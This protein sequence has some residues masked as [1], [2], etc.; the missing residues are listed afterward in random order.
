MS[1]LGKTFQTLV[2]KILLA[3]VSLLGSVLIVR[4]VGAEGQGVLATVYAFFM[5]ISTIFFLSLGSSMIYHI[6][7][8]GDSEKYFSASLIMYFALTGLTIL[9]TIVFIDVIQVYILK[10]LN[11]QYLY[12]GWALISANNLGKISSAICRATHNSNLFNSILVLQR[13][14]YF[15]PILIGYLLSF[16]IDT[17]SVIWVFL[18]STFISNL[19]AIVV[20]RK[21]FSFRKIEFNSMRQLLS[22]SGKGHIGVMIQVIN[23]KIDI[24]ILNALLTNPQVGYYSIAVLFA[25]LVWY[26]PDSVATFLYPK[27]S[28][29]NN[30]HKSLE[31]TMRINRIVLFV[32]IIIAFIIFYISPYL[33]PAIYPEDFKNSIYAIQLLIIGVAIYSINKILTKF[34]TGTGRPIVGSIISL[35]GLF[36]NIPL[37]VYLI[38]EY[39][40]NGAAIASTVAYSVMGLCA[41]FALKYLHPN[42][43]V[44]S[45]LLINKTDV[46]YLYSVLV[47]IFHRK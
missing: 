29:F 16:K 39:G 26:V 21:F 45:V 32:S 40:I 19:V 9:L 20:N 30:T 8:T 38:P 18:I 35:I 6:N 41:I 37:L 10:D 47:K 34:F 31:L 22:F 5:I 11:L 13:L 12:L 23:T 7:H 24:L 15:L 42:V 25:Q 33:I 46:K 1:L 36:V 17:I 2:T 43:R 44:T 14:G 28:K 3:V 4:V 27:I